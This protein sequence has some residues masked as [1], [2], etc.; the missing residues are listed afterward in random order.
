MNQKLIVALLLVTI[1]L[2]VTS[3]IVIFNVDSGGE[4]VDLTRFGKF[5]ENNQ[6]SSVGL[7]IKA[8]IGVAG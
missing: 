6:R 5:I 8:P 1:V 4:D 3:M 2:S 7:V